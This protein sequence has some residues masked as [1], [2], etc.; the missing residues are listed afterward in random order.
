RAASELKAAVLDLETQEGRAVAATLGATDLDGFGE[1]DEI[2]ERDP[3]LDA[4]ERH[5]TAAS[6]PWRL[7]RVDRRLPGGSRSVDLEALGLARR[8]GAERLVFVDAGDPVFAEAKSLAHEDPAL[9]QFV[10]L[11]DLSGRLELRGRARAELLEGVALAIYASQVG[12]HE[13]DPAR[14]TR[15]APA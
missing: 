15:G 13:R 10:W 9:A 2:C 6:R 1:L 3:F 14:A 4:I 7:R 11:D 8:W 5:L 12:R